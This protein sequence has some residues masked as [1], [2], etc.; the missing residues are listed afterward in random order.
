METYPKVSLGERCIV[1]VLK[2]KQIVGKIV[3]VL[4]WWLVRLWKLFATTLPRWRYEIGVGWGAVARREWGEEAGM[5]GCC[6][7]GKWFQ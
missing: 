3:G 2:V 7:I 5:W 4:L 6:P 1:F